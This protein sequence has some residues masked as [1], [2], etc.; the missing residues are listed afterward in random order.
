[1]E[2]PEQI[3]NLNAEIEELYEFVKFMATSFDEVGRAALLFMPERVY[4]PFVIEAV[5]ERIKNPPS[6][7]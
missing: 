6:T 5:R 2:R 4:H 3:Q 1:M 7:S